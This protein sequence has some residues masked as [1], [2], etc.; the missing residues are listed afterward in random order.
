MTTIRP[1][2]FCILCKVL[3]NPKKYKKIGQKLKIGQTENGQKLEIGQEL[4]I[5]QKLQNGQN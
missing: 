5:G 2:Y 1:I 3:P 4:K